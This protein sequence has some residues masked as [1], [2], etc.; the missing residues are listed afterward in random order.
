MAYFDERPERQKLIN[1]IQ[2]LAIKLDVTIVFDAIEM[3][4]YGDLMELYID[5]LGRDVE[6]EFPSTISIQRVNQQK[7][8]AEC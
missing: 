5:L 6:Q 4:S 7:E 2:I 8:I 1:Q 3:M